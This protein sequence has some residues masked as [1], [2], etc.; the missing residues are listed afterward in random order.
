MKADNSGGNITEEDATL[1]D[2][3][4]GLDVEDEVPL[5][6]H[7]QRT[8]VFN[9]LSALHYQGN[10]Y[11]QTHVSERKHQEA[12]GLAIVFCQGMDVL[13]HL[14]PSRKS[15]GIKGEIREHLNI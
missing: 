5:K 14:H 7:F 12:T 8:R 1:R 6:N 3:A 11:Y 15:F 13:Q 4:N 9:F 10:V 2:E